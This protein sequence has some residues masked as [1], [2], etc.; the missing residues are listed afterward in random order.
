M[1]EIAPLRS[2]IACLIWSSRSTPSSIRPFSRM[3]SSRIFM[4]DIRSSW[5]T[6]FSINQ[7]SVLQ[8]VT[9][10]G[11]AMGDGV[12]G[13]VDDDQG[14]RDDRRGRQRRIVPDQC[15]TDRLRDEQQQDQIEDRDLRKPAL[16]A[17]PDDE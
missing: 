17:E 5:T 3:S 9:H 8:D 15:L 1:I 12:V 4:L 11:P 2:K 10:V 13:A 6:P 7:R 16:A 14:D